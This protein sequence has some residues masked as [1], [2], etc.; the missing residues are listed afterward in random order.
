MNVKSYPQSIW[1]KKEIKCTILMTQLK[2]SRCIWRAS[3]LRRNK[4]TKQNKV[5]R[6]SSIICKVVTQDKSSPHW[7]NLKKVRPKVKQQ[8]R[9]WISRSNTTWIHGTPGFHS[10][11]IH[12]K[13]FNSWV[14]KVIK[15]GIEWKQTNLWD[16]IRPH[17]L[18]KTS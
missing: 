13:Y 16:H 6:I 3:T 17:H 5:L 1:W 10:R 7:P 11:L 4:N 12:F 15:E 18:N 2:K 14:H 9:I 8:Q